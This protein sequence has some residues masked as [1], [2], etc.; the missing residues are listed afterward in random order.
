MKLVYLLSSKGYL[1]TDDI[2]HT[3]EEL[4]SDDVSDAFNFKTEEALEKWIREIAY[5]TLNGF[6]TS[7]PRPVAVCYVLNQESM[8]LSKELHSPNGD[9]MRVF[10]GKVTLVESTIQ[11][12]VEQEILRWADEQ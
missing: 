8:N 11:A 3:T 10:T 6:F 5:K 1:T 9:Y 7:I 4:F 12:I 2:I